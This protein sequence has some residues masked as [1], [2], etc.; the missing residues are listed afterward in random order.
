MLTSATKLYGRGPIL[1]IASQKYV[2]RVLDID[3]MV[4]AYEQRKEK[5]TVKQFLRSFL[6]LIRWFD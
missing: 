1:C 3:N 2:V 6:T 5:R 4:N